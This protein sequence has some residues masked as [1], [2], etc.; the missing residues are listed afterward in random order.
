MELA[1]FDDFDSRLPQ[2]ARDPPVGSLGRPESSREWG[3]ADNPLRNQKSLVLDL[4]ATES[5]EA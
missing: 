5:G 3:S 4:I 1:G 2:T